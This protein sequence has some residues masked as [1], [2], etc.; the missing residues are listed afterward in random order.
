[1]D[2]NWNTYLKS[3]LSFGVIDHN[4]KLIG[5]SL[6]Y[7]I[8][9]PFQIQSISNQI[10][11]LTPLNTL[12]DIPLENRLDQLITEEHLTRIMRSHVTT[13]DPTLTPAQR[14]TIMYFI[15]KHLLDVAKTNQY[16]AVITANTSSVTQ[17]L[18]EH[19]LKYDTNHVTPA[20]QCYE[21]STGKALF[22][23]AP[24]HYTIA[25]S[26]KYM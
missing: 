12:I 4:N 6:S 16:Q 15:E 5:L 21:P 25:I 22:P 9:K 19:V 1:M 24:S 26:V 17:Q 8:S 10:T 13:V 18:A 2:F 11:L 23:D 14:L 20:S 7:D 3:N